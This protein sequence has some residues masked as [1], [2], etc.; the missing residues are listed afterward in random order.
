MYIHISFA[1]AAVRALYDS[2]QCSTP[3]L[4]D[5]DSRLEDFRQGLGCS[6]THLFIGS[7]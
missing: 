7:G 4:H 6:G 3:G 2:S 5:Q 1:A